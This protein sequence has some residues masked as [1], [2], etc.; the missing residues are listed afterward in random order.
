MVLL[1]WTSNV[2]E[3][4]KNP[5]SSNACSQMGEMLHQQFPAEPEKGD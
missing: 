5:C 3:A 1:T 4:E 2:K